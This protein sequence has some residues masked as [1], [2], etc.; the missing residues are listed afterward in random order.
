M[1]HG[2]DISTD[3]SDAED[4]LNRIT[5][6]GDRAF[7]EVFANKGLICH[8]SGTLRSSFSVRKRNFELFFGHK[9]EESSMSLDAWMFRS[10]SKFICKSALV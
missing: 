10:L 1:D 3:L 6:T 8:E 7:K 5:Y 2:R 9:L 4:K